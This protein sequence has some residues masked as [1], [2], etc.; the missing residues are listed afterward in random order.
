MFHMTFQQLQSFV[1]RIG[2]RPGGQP[3]ERVRIP[4]GKRQAQCWPVHQDRPAHAQRMVQLSEAH[5]RTVRPTKLYDQPSA[6]LELKIP[7][8]TAEVLETVLR[9]CVAWRPRACH[10]VTL[11]QVRHSFL[12]RCIGCRKDNRTDNCLCYFF[13]SYFLFCFVSLE[14]SLSPSIVHL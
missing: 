5:P 11:C 2:R 14:M 6:P 8:L 4:R 10:Y 13:W 3:N 7:I 12:I 9:G 1:Q